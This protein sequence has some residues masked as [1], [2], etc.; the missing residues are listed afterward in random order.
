MYVA[1]VKLG[2]FQREWD[3]GKA[4]WL[5][6]KWM[7]LPVRFGSRIRPVGRIY[8]EIELTLNW[9]CQSILHLDEYDLTLAI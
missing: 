7:R 6:C 3:A 2:R 5:H 8:F 9:L 1:R 4:L